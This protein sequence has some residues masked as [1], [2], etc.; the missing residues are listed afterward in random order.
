MPE[1]DGAAQETELSE[2]VGRLRHLIDAG[3]LPEDGRLPPERALAAEFCTGRRQVRRAL[4]HL[5]AEGL[6]WRHQG[7]GTFAGQPPDPTTKIAAE[8][9]AEVD[10]LG[11]MEARLCLEPSIAAL[12]AERAQAEDVARL[13]ALAARI[14]L[15]ADA[16]TAELWDGA[17]H[18]TIARVA[19]NR[20]LLTAFGL[21][22]EVRH[23]PGW[24][25]PR[26]RARTAESARISDRQHAAIIDAIAAHDP[27]GAA[28]AMRLHLE[29]L[30]AGLAQSLE[31]Q[32]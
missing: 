24:Q 12:C 3:R 18:R 8:I 29:T 25:A 20:I 32:G 26:A 5:E 6:I 19:G 9:V 30:A 10:P 21:V 15:P 22:D 27:V 1:P 28:A 31:G 13:R 4:D 14:K 7:K 17:L 11:V 23:H 2:V 16:E